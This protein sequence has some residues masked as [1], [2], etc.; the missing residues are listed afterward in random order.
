MLPRITIRVFPPPSRSFLQKAFWGG[1]LALGFLL[2]VVG[3]WP[4]LGKPFQG[5]TLVVYVG[6]ASK[7]P[8]EEASR[9]FTRL[10]G[11]KVEL[12]I[13]SSGKML[14][15]LKLARRGDLYF[16][17]S[18]D[19]MEMAKRQRLVRPGTERRIVYLIPAINVPVSNPAKIRRL[20]D[21]VRPGV[22]VGIARPDTVCVGLYAAEIL[23]KEGL[24]H[25][26]KRNIVT[27]AE[28]C[29]KTAQ[30]VS[31]GLVDAVIGWDVF[32]KWDPRHI[33]TL[34]LRPEQVSRIGYLPIAITTFSRQPELAQ[35]FI[36]FISGPRGKAIFKRWGYLTSLSEARKF[37]LS[38]TPVGGEG[39]LSKGWQ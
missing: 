16:P 19:F 31:L 34:Y 21:L 9:V 17:G 29:E 26:V 2:L 30:I 4:Q 6:S 1:L 3:V 35:A 5:K 20:E 10:T 8:I 15:E 14:S 18:S 12:H 37:C 7:P 22:R 11:A 39:K 28:S 38:N 24:T 25:K 27:Y 23:D 36:A 33:K 13:G 32:E